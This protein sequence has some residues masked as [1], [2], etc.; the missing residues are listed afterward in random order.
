MGNKQG[1]IKKKSWCSSEKKWK[2]NV[3]I[4]SEMKTKLQ[5]TQGK[6]N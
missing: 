3:K 6:I 5:G 2:E 1:E 4:I